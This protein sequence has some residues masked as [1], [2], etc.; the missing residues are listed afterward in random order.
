MLA[1][2]RLAVVGAVLTIS[3][4]RA[5]WRGGGRQLRIADRLERRNPR[6]PKRERHHRKLGQVPRALRRSAHT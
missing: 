1:Q 5:P 6:L 3:G 2:R 4:F